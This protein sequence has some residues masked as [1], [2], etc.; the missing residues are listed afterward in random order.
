MKRNIGFFLLVIILIV[1][2]V[3]FIYVWDHS[4]V[5]G[6]TPTIS[7]PSDVLEVSVEDNEAIFEGV[8]AS[9]EEDGNLTDKVYIESISE[10]DENQERT[11]TYTVFDSDD[12]VARTTRKIK[13]TDYEAPVFTLSKALCIYYVTS[14]EEY[15]DYVSASSVVDGDISSSITIDNINYGDSY[16]VQSVTY[17]V[18]D[19]CGVTTTETYNVTKINYNATI[20]IELEEYLIKVDVGQTIYPSSYITS[21]IEDDI[22]HDP[23][24]YDIE[25]S[26]NYDPYT[27][28]TYEF[29][30][31]IDHSPSY[32]ITKLT[33][34]VEE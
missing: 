27:P 26:D 19:S 13:Y 16:D 20:D 3:G 25:I 5:S 12:N 1:G 9:D 8:S 21:V 22:E 29:I 34:I 32:G 33:V 2:Y 7:A 14:S 18:T 30:Y 24:D 15:K 10:F 6:S 28:G 31:R 23:S 17:S 4:K 11:V